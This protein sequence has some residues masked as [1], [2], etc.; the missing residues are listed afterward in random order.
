MDEANLAVERL[1]HA[2]STTG[3]TR[4]AARAAMAEGTLAARRGA[5]AVA[6]QKLRAARAN[7]A[8]CSEP[9]VQL[10]A[11]I[12][13]GELALRA[14]DR[15]L[16]RE[17][18]TRAARL[19]ERW[20]RPVSRGRARAMLALMAMNERQLDAA[21]AEARRAAEA[22]ALHPRDQAWATIGLIRA[23]CAAVARQAPAARQWWSL[24]R[25]RGLGQRIE[26]LHKHALVTLCGAMEG[27][28]LEDMEPAV[29]E[30]L[31][32]LTASQP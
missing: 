18:L 16:A 32:V 17:R 23:T 30:A 2:A 5:W 31:A 24:A 21:E 11:L 6:D 15:L 20:C 25:E 1:N 9:Q 7:A 4:A 12:A 28:E 26:P 10:D 3:D 8:T 13:L 19:A 29:W 14:E 27:L 22:L